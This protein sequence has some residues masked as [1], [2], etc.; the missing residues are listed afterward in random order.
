MRYSVFGMRF[1]V[2]GM[3]YSV[4]SVAFQYAVMHSCPHAANRSPYTVFKATHKNI[5]KQIHKTSMKPFIVI[6]AYNEEKS[7]GTVLERLIK[8]GYENIVVT[9]DSSTDNT[10]AVL[11]HCAEKYPCVRI[12]S[13][14]INRGQGAALKTG[15]DHAVE[16]GAEIIV[17]FDADGQHNPKEIRQ[18]IAPIVNGDVDVVLGSRFLA[19]NGE[20]SKKS[21]IPAFKRAVLK[22]GILFTWLFSG[23]KLTDTHNG[24]RALSRKAAQQIQI[25]QDRMEHASEI[26]DEIC[27]KN[28]PFTEVPVTI[29]YSNYA[30]QKGQSGLNSVKIAAKLILRR[31]MR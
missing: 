8:E 29:T 11:E 24:F 31:M 17:T 30:R 28:I 2:F 20:Q 27:K 1:A 15:I 3:R 5:N 23:K 16:Q 26:I 10:C 19:K 21:D 6:A 13:H 22:G 4:C 18:L 7:I 14:L 12:L 25:R 9:N